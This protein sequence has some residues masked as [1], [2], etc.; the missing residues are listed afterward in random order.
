[1]PKSSQALGHVNAELKTKVSE[2]SVSIMVDVV[3]NPTLTYHL[4]T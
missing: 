1:V 3:T 4:I 2:I